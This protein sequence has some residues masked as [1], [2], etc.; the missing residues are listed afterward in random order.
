MKRAL[1]AT[2][3][4]HVPLPALDFKRMEEASGLTINIRARRKIEAAVKYFLDLIPELP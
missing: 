1:F 2:A 3:F 4:F